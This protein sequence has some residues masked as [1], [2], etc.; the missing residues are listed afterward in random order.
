MNKQEIIGEVVK[1]ILKHCK[2]ERI[3]LYGSHAIGEGTGTSDIDIAFEDE[4]FKKDFLITDEIEKLPTLLKIDI[5][6]ISFAD[7][8]FKNRVKSTGQ[9][10]YSANKKLRAQDGLYNYS[11]AYEQFADAVNRK[12]ELYN[13]G[14]SDFYLD[15]VIKRFEFTYEMGWKAI[16]RYLD[17]IGIDCKFPRNCIK[18]AF[19]QGLVE[20]E[21]VWLDMIEMRNLSSHVYSEAEMSVIIDKLKIYKTAFRSLKKNIENGLG[22]IGKKQAV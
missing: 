5:K 15:L 14:Y 6:N 4:K 1:I 19:S 10:L 3:Y 11:R 9:V 16:K 8:R 2:P 21:D 22:K 7:K 18:E 13:A 12:K 20:D 17:F